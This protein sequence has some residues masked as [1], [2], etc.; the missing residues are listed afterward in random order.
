MDTDTGGNG[1]L[2]RL[3]LFAASEVEVV[4]DDLAWV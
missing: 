1:R 2:A 3:W 4:L